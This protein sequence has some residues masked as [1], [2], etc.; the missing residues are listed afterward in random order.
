METIRKQLANKLLAQLSTEDGAEPDCNKEALFASLDDEALALSNLPVKVISIFGGFLA[1][2]F[3]TGFLMMAGAWQSSS[4]LCFMGLLFIAGAVV[5]VEQD[6]STFLSA[7]AVS[8]LLIGFGLFGA[9]LGMACES[10][11]LPFIVLMLLSAGLMFATTHGLVLFL[12]S[13]IFMGSALSLVI[14]ANA[15]AVLHIFV[16]IHALLLIGW[17][18]G[19]SRLIT[20]NARLNKAYRPLRIGLVVGFAALMAMM[21]SLGIAKLYDIQIPYPW[22]SGIVLMLATLIFCLNTLQGLQ[23]T[24]GSGSHWY[25]LMPLLMLPL[26]PAPAVLG[27]F[28]LIL[29]GFYSRHWPSLVVGIAAF[30]YALFIFYYDLQLSLLEKSGMLLLSGGWFLIGYILIKR[31]A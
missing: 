25:L 30:C 19:E 7:L 2:V 10:V 27:S 6:T 24:T 18:L 4:A 8:F 3:F 26:I 12:L 16:A 23:R 31:Y 22:V 21:A 9:G 5:V 15:F 17:T 13:L 20:T 11:S 28:L 1:A 14:E 29:L